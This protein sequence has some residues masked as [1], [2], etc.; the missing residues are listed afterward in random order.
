[1]D[2]LSQFKIL[3]IEISIEF[4]RNY[5]TY[6]DKVKLLKDDYFWTYLRDPYA[7]REKP[8]ISLEIL[9]GASKNL[10]NEIESGIYLNRRLIYKVLNN[11]K[12]GIV[13]VEKFVHVADLRGVGWT[14]FK[15]ITKKVPINE[16]KSSFNFIKTGCILKNDIFTDVS[17]NFV[18]SVDAKRL[19]NFEIN[20]LIHI[21]KSDFFIYRKER[22]HVLI[23]GFNGKYSNTDSFS[24]FNLYSNTEL[25]LLIHEIQYSRCNK[26]IKKKNY[27][28]C[29]MMPWKQKYKCIL[30]TT[31]SY[32]S[33][34]KNIKVI[35][36]SRKCKFQ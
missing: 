14:K 28:A 19:K 35:S 5:F 11:T 4:F 33:R 16:V 7:W 27:I 2:P 15:V 21:P 25:L 13:K 20:T 3:P 9:K 6:D 23:S 32:M 10:L 34:K 24:H 12:Q 30:K 31:F 22:Y 29:K 36:R 17:G 26:I 1:M 8:K 18:Y